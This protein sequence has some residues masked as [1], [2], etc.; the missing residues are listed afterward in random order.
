MA[1]TQALGTMTAA[2]VPVVADRRRR[3]GFGVTGWLGAG[4][5]AVIALAAVLAPLVTPFGPVDPSGGAL[6]APNGTHWL[7]TDMY[8]RDTFTRIVYGARVSLS[9]GLLVTAVTFVLG[10]ALGLVSGFFGG[11]LDAVIG[12]CTDA[13]LALPGILIAISIVAVLG[14]GVVN[15]AIALVLVYVPVM[16][17]MVRGSTIAVRQRLHVRSARAAGAGPVRILL[18][19]IAPYVLGPALVQAT[20]VFAHAVLYEAS[21]SFLGLGVQ[22]PTP[23]WGNM[24]ADGLE[25]LSANPLQV[26]IP[27]LVISLVVLAVNLF[28][29]ALRD[30]IDPEGATR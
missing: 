3:R 17:R 5:L 11:W 18:R 2:D 24:I 7:G 23:T 22:P 10:M 4:V 14:T 21:L 12:R 8:S 20:F 1:E 9:V 19:H 16:L 27:S 25:H 30:A 28:G 15:V 13:L 29:D 6:E 26:V